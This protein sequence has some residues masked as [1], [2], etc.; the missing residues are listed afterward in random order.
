MTSVNLEY[1]SSRCVGAEKYGVD[2][3]EV[4][5]KGTI[6]AGIWDWLVLG[7]G[8]ETGRRAIHHIMVA[9]KSEGM[10]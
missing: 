4:R 6:R 9:C 10:A 2:L 8:T 7:E 1:P 3:V 5:L